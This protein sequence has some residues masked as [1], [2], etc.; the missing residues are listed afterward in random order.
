MGAYTFKSIFH[1]A[2]NLFKFNCEITHEFVSGTNQYLAIRVNFLA[3]TNTKETT[4]VYQK[5]C[6]L[7]VLY[8]FTKVFQ[9]L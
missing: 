1:R 6:K 3:Q 4:F 9:S 2:L 7:C 8:N 5:L